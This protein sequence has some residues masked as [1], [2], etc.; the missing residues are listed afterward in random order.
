VYSTHA[1]H[2]GTQCHIT[3]VSPAYSHVF[4]ENSVYEVGDENSEETIQQF[5]L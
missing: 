5:A 4:L 3:N 1:S 2:Y